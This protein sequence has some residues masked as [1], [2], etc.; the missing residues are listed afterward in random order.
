MKRSKRQGRLLQKRKIDS[1]IEE[2]GNFFRIM[3][4]DRKGNI[5]IIKD[6][7]VF[8]E[9]KKIVDELPQSLT[10]TDY[11]IHYNESSRVLYT[12]IV[13]NNGEQ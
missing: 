6:C 11:Y 1:N 9:A 2:S 8:E 12:R 13:G 4:V 10:E 5:T 3:G 7:R